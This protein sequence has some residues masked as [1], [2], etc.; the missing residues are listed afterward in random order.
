MN[1]P[2]HPV[3]QLQLALPDIDWITEASRIARL[4]QDFSWFSPVLSRQ[5]A[6][7]SAQAVARPR[8]LDEITR[9]V[10]QC[11]RLRIPI[12]VRGAGTGNY[13]QCVPLHGGLVLDMSGFNQFLWARAGAARAQAGIRLAEFEKQARA[14]AG[15]ELRCMPSTFRSATLGGL[16][17]GGF[18]GVGSIN[19]GPLAARGNVLGVLALTVEEVPRLVEL[20][21][22]E[23]LAMHH[24]WGTN[25]LVLEVEL[26]MAP[27]VDWHEQLV[28]FG[29][30][31]DA[32]EFGNAV[33]CAP[34][35]HK[36]EVA[37]L[38]D[39]IPGY[40]TPLAEHLPAGCHAVILATG[41]ASDAAVRELAA[42][43]R[44]E[45]T[46]AK[47]AEEVARSNRTLLEYTWNHTTLVA[48]KVDRSITYL[49]S[50]FAA[51]RHLEQVRAMHALLHPEVQMHAEFIRTLD[52][53]VTCSALQIVKFSTEE[54]LQEIMALHR[55]H[56]VRINDP[57][58]FVVE[59]GKA[60][61]ALAP[62]VL[63]A[64][65][66]FD[67]LGLLNPGKVRAWAQTV[68]A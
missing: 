18:G 35:I 56:G 51:G 20:R 24:L 38:A 28:V 67:P 4:S 26:A 63:A 61:G 32:L 60:G 46:Y 13:G 33:A 34:G 31:D 36:R 41:A 2:V 27:A 25:G 14:N 9:V 49:Q 17:G 37:L 58:V 29:S 1:A 19:H 64:K 54:R 21:G 10:A 22:P 62:D 55:A 66:R 15:L 3:E 42:Q 23:A 11:A 44:G 40:L 47:T 5:L 8:N 39:P 43:W 30:F 12:T 65:R 52:G 68:H 7:K 53:Q 6:G 57:H 59:D 16:F 45:L 50:A 48:L